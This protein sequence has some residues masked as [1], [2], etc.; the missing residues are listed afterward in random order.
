MKRGDSSGNRRF[1]PRG[2]RNIEHRDLFFGGSAGPEVEPE[3]NR[4]QYLPR[5]HAES[6]RGPDRHLS[7]LAA[8]P[9]PFQSTGVLET[10]AAGR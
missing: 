9:P 7:G 1:R 10:P 8:P 5:R 6:R 4:V 3:R 2:G